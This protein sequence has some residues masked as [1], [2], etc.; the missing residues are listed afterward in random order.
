M[1]GIGAQPIV[2]PYIGSDHPLTI[3]EDELEQRRQEFL[4]QPCVLQDVPLILTMRECRCFQIQGSRSLQLAYARYVLLHHAMLYP[5]HSTLL[6]IA[7]EERD[8]AYF[9]RFL[10][11]QFQEDGCR[12]LCHDLRSMAA[13]AI[14]LRQA[15]RPILAISL[16]SSFTTFLMQNAHDMPMA[17]LACHESLPSAEAI[18]LKQGCGQFCD[19]RFTWQQESQFATAMHQ[20][21]NIGGQMRQTFPKLLSFL[22]LYHVN[23]MMQLQIEKRWQQHDSEHSLQ[24]QIGITQDG[25]ILTLDLHERSHGPHGIVA[26]M[27]GSG[28]SEWL[29]TLLLSLA[30]NYHPCDCAFVLIDYKGGGMAKTLERLPHTAGIITNLDGSLIQRSLKSLDVELLRRQRLFAQVMEQTGAASMN[31]DVYQKLYHEHQ[32]T[33]VIPHLIIAADEFAELKQQEP[34]FMEQLIRIARIGRSLGIHLILATQKPSGVVDDQIWSNARFHVCLKVADEADSMDMLKRKEGA[35]IKAVG[36]FYLQVGCDELF[37]E[38][39]SA[40]AKT[41]YD[42]QQ[43]GVGRALIKEMNAAGGI[44]REWKREGNQPVPTQCNALMDTLC[45]LAHKQAQFPP[46]LWLDPLP[47]TLSSHQ[48]RKDCFALADDPDHCRQ[49]AVSV[50][51]NLVNTIFLAQKIHDAGRAISAFL[52]ALLSSEM[53]HLPHIVMIDGAHDLSQWDQTGAIY[54]RCTLEQPEDIAFIMEML[55]QEKQ[56]QS[57]DRWLLVIHH[58]AAFLDAVDAADQ[59]LLDL[60]FDHGANGIQILLSATSGADIRTRLLSQFD[61]YFVMHLQDEQEIRSLIGSAWR[62][63]DN[64]LRAIWKKQAEAYEV[65]F[66]DITDCNLIVQEKRAVLHLPLLEEYPSYSQLK[67]EASHDGFVIGRTLTQRKVLS[68]PIAGN[69]LI[70]GAQYHSFIN[71]IK[72][73]AEIEQWPIE[74]LDDLDHPLSAQ[75]RIFALSANELMRNLHHPVVNECMQNQNVIW[76]GFGL[77]EYRYLWNLP[78]SI[79]VKHRQDAIWCK[80]EVIS[81]RRISIL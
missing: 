67:K 80:E 72:Q 41:P 26:G 25:G 63:H 46:P 58:A 77:E 7:C 16:A 32:V 60:A 52:S 27:T 3:Q 59:W 21:C 65:Q 76:C 4:D 40:Y 28:K 50:Q 48:V 34:Q 29:I 33:E 75:M 47:E 69:W 70:S 61:N 12:L 78:P 18:V 2:M 17:L 62:M 43:S 31:I 10:P 51:D 74:C 9:P 56:R 6:F 37:M 5:P 45:Q 20:L 23:T 13:M 8:A 11:H 73:I 35:Q 66:V 64:A 81:F 19:Q 22:E 57:K 38:G 71:L 49:F 36:R 30:V 14:E 44:L 24:A 53:E 68:L 55:K 1:I 39:Q 42:P 54:G 15:K 79:S